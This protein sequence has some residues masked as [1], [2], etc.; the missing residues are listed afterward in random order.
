MCVVGGACILSVCLL[1]K[2]S[3]HASDKVSELVRG[4]E[5]RGGDS[6]RVE[7]RV[8]GEWRVRGDSWENGEGRIELCMYIH[9]YI[10]VCR[11][12][13]HGRLPWKW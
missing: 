9:T 8:G 13:S 6:G 1:Q 10:H 4:R 5:G 7:G 2:L 3:S 12:L 11:S